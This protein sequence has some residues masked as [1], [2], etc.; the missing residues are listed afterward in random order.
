MVVHI[1]R[2]RDK[3]LCKMSESTQLALAQFQS[4]KIKRL[5]KSMLFRTAV[6]RTDFWS[7]KFWDARSGSCRNRC[8]ERRPFVISASGSLDL[9]DFHGAWLVQSGTSQGAAVASATTQFHWQDQSLSTESSSGEKPSAC[10][11][12][13]GVAGSSPG[14]TSYPNTSQRL[15]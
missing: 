10:F 11:S 4:L 12:V 13:L 1:W 5:V 6:W 7:F 2:E 8:R 9:V 3:F 14:W 15:P